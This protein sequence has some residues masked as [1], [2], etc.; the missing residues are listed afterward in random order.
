M[1]ATFSWLVDGERV[2]IRHNKVG[3]LATS[4]T[5]CFLFE[6]L[7][8]FPPARYEEDNHG[9]AHC[10][11]MPSNLAMLINQCRLPAFFGK[12]SQGR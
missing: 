8:G 4:I 1:P 6:M 2:L 10:P 7:V 11:I 12:E 5:P 9:Q 3:E